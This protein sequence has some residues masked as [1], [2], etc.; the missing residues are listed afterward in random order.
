MNKCSYTAADPST[1]W[2]KLDQEVWALRTVKAS[3][4][5]QLPQK[6]QAT[7]D[8]VPGSNGIR[9]PFAHIR[10]K[11]ANLALSV[12][13]AQA[14]STMLQLAP[15]SLPH[16][17]RTDYCPS[18]PSFLGYIYLYTYIPVFTFNQSIHVCHLYTIL[19]FSNWVNSTNYIL[20]SHSLPACATISLNIRCMVDISFPHLW[21]IIYTANYDKRKFNYCCVPSI[22]AACLGSL[23]L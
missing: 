18:M 7:G 22:I 11:L 9:A 10:P 8:C 12:A 17:R 14:L 3:G 21:C 13:N 1:Q 15:P 20:L 4:P 16:Q 6:R 2:N 19:L 5:P 23:S